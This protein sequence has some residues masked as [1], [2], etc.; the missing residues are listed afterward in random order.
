[1]LLLS[2]LLAEGAV[3][4]LGGRSLFAPRP[5]VR[6]VPV[7]E[8]ATDAARQAAGLSA[9]KGVLRGHIDPRVGIALQSGTALSTVDATYSARP[10]GV[11]SRPEPMPPNAGKHVV[12][13]GDSVAFGYGVEDDQTLAQQL[14]RILASVRGPDLAPIVATTVA[15]PGWNH[16]NSVHFLIDHL[17]LLDPDIVVFLPIENDLTD[18][19][20]I[21]EG[22][23]RALSPDPSSSDPWLS[24]HDEPL[25]AFIYRSTVAAQNR[26]QG[27]E[28]TSAVGPMA[29]TSDLTAESMG[30]YDA[31][32][33]SVV[34]LERILNR[35][36]TRLMLAF[37]AENHYGLTLQARLLERGLA[38]PV[39]PLFSQLPK[40]FQLETDP[41]PS[42]DGLGLMARWIAEE[43]LALGWIDGAEEREL[44]PLPG[45][46][47][48]H[49]VERRSAQDVLALARQSTAAVRDQLQRRIDLSS[50]QGVH[51]IYGGLNQ[52]GSMGSAFAA[53]LAGG[54]Q[55]ELVVAA[56]EEL[57]QLYPLRVAVA[58]DGINV[59][60]LLIEAQGELTQVFTRPPGIAPETPLEVRLSPELWGV[61]V[62][63]RRSQL[64]SC[65]LRSLRSIR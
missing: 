5:V 48:R 46:V 43:L 54:T 14:E 52:D 18:T 13:L 32:A 41:H 15:V 37:I 9:A 65:W 26:G 21:T 24:V 50:G 3:S 60:E 7:V 22:G 25:L 19:F 62:A 1:V 38:I 57:P 42:V 64:T 40:V 10:D 33:D 12:I 59:G 8:L 58:L 29:L 20:G 36:D 47:T 45:A 34:L 17:A 53:V 2:A 11:R 56:F 61:A 23:H 31:A 30:R 51:Q 49:R 4:L 44:E 28:L 6:Q 55:V 16:R 63:Y 27:A 39:A 35:V